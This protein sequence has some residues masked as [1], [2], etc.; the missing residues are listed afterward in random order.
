MIRIQIKD[1]VA[2]I[3]VD[4]SDPAA[5]NRKLDAILAMMRES[6]NREVQMSIEMDTLE[7]AVTRNT[8][9]DDSILALAKTIAAQIEANAGDKVKMLALAAGLN[10]SSDK[11][12]EWVVAN[13]P[14]APPA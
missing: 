3:Q 4:E 12:S 6:R 5:G 14:S 8:T 7:A 13:T 9:V 10:A 2:T 1:G 11:I